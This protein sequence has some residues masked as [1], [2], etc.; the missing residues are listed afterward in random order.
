M[1][2]SGIKRFK[3]LEEENTRLKQVVA[4]LNLDKAM[5]QQNLDLITKLRFSSRNNQ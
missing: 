3:S 4:D 1:G 5:L 2:T